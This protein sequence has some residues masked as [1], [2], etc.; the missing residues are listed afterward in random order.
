MSK[1]I[2]ISNQKGGVSKTTT[3]YNIGACLAI[4]HNKKV[5]LVDIDPQANLSEYLG[6]EPDGQPTMTQL[7]MAACMGSII[8][9][10]TVCGAIRHSESANVDYIPSDIN[11]ASSESLM[12]TAISRETIL[13]RILSDDVVSKYDYVIIDCLPSLGSLLINALTCAD[14]V[15]IPVQT[16]KF[17][18]DGLQALDALFQQIKAAINPNISYLGILP[19]MVERTKVSRAAL[20]TLS[21]KYGDML[22]KT[23]ISKSV[24][25]PKS[26]ESRI[27][28]CVTDSKLGNEYKN[29]TN[30]ILQ[31]EQDTATVA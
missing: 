19:T 14:R 26:A 25:A 20:D 12:A 27:P 17:S 31:I 11:L 24:E 4:Q 2:A 7:I 29:L 22:L 5:L 16:Q 15:L 21:E 30:E 9:N 6:F 3:A 23:Y 10:D 13:K 28:L 8:P 1:I 18:L